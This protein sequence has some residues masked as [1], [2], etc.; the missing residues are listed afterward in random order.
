MKSLLFLFA[1]ISGISFAQTNIIAAKS[2]S[3]DPSQSLQEKDNFDLP[4][5]TRIVKSVK[6][7]KDDCIVEKCEV[8]MWETQIVHDTICDHPFLQKGQIDVNRIKSM[9]PEGTIYWFQL[10]ERR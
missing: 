5:E 2:H 6:Y 9:Y 3:G 10:G 8:T 7:L 4:N 1:F